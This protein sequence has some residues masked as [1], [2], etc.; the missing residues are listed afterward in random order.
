MI[1]VDNVL[2]A[3]HA[4]SMGGPTRWFWKSDDQPNYGADYM[5][6]NFVKPANAKKRRQ[7][8]SMLTPNTT[9]IIPQQFATRLAELCTFWVTAYHCRQSI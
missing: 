6:A 8:I 7:A 4:F 3:E 5:A 1:P 9:G 2:P